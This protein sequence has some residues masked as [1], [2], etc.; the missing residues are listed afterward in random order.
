MVDNQSRMKK[1]Y[2]QIFGSLAVIALGAVLFYFS[3]DLQ[4]ERIL[5]SLGSFPKGTVL[6]VLL[7]S[8]AQIVFMVLRFW[9]LLPSEVPLSKA[10]RC[11]VFGHL[12]NNFA[13]ARAGEAL[14]IILLSKGTNPI[15]L[16]T[17]TGS[18]AADRIADLLTL[19]FIFI[20]FGAYRSPVF[21]FSLPALDI[22][23]ALILGAVFLA[24]G[25]LLFTNSKIKNHIKAG[26]EKLAFGFRN[27]ANPKKFGLSF[28]FGVSCWYAEVVA[29]YLLC[30]AQGLTVSAGEII[31]IIVILNLG[32]S[33]AFSVANVGTFEA[34]MVF[35]L[36]R[37]HCPTETAIAIAVCHHAIQLVAVVILSSFLALRK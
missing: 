24:L 32:L 23:I 13:P 14:K 26:L 36:S 33:L 29:L 10:S 30:S 17:A 20:A 5:N 27:L 8:S 35:A 31:G 7:C 3:K 37:L 19:I 21:Q 11:L 9:T 1:L 15:P 6:L 16:L 12:A 4:F 28:L 25:V 2:L 34:S 22:R 18:F